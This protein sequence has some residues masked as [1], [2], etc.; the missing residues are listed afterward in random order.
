MPT[1]PNS[2]THGTS[3]TEDRHP[4]NPAATRQN[5]SS[6]C[7]PSGGSSGPEPQ[8]ERRPKGSGTAT[9]RRR[10]L[11]SGVGLLA[12][13]ASGCVTEN[14]SQTSEDPTGEVETNDDPTA[15]TQ[16]FITALDQ[17]DAATIQSLARSGSELEN[18]SASDLTV[19]EEVDLE[20]EQTNLSTRGDDTA[21]VE[22][23]LSEANN[24]DSATFDLNLLQEDGRW[25]I[26]TPSWWD[27]YSS[28]QSRPEESR[29]EANNQITNRVIEVTSVGSINGGV[30]DELK[31]TIRLAAGSE[32]VPLDG[33]L[34]QLVTEDGSWNLLSSN[35]DDVSNADGVFSY[36][37][38]QDDDSS[39]ADNHTMNDRSDRTVITIG[40]DGSGDSIDSTLGPSQTGTM[41][42]ITPSGGETTWT[43]VVPDSLEGKEKV[44][45]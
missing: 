34:I 40:L 14:E 1:R 29:T 44:E 21:T 7:A 37:T 27:E 22:V 18:V 35:S 9:S 15:A 19:F 8:Q 12:I 36:R 20:L 41:H 42:V 2:S 43:L 24:S 23:T 17:G 4:D 3:D 45:I 31:F 28:F 32:A 6:Q 33:M 13:A 30:V 39:I 38:L 11:A 26:D 25:T 16:K 10:L 5:R